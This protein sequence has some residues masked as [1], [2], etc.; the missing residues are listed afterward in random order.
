MPRAPR[1][2]PDENRAPTLQQVQADRERL[3]ADAQRTL[4]AWD[5]IVGQQEG[6]NHRFRYRFDP[7]QRRVVDN[8]DALP[9]AQAA[10]GGIGAGYYFAQAAQ[11]LLDGTQVP[12]RGVP[13]NASSASI[14]QPNG[15]W[16]AGCC[17]QYTPS[18]IRGM[19]ITNSERH[20]DRR[21]HPH[22]NIHGEHM[23]RKAI[24]S[25][26]ACMTVE[27][28]NLAPDRLPAATSMIFR[29]VRNTH[30]LSN[31]DF[32]SMMAQFHEYIGSNCAG[33][34]P[35]NIFRAMQMFFMVPQALAEIAQVGRRIL[36][37]T[38]LSGTVFMTD[39]I[40]TQM[41]WRNRLDAAFFLFAIKPS[42][43][44]RFLHKIRHRYGRATGFITYNGMNQLL[45]FTCRDCGQRQPIFLSIG[46]GATC[47]FCQH[48]VVHNAINPSHSADPI[49]H[50]LG[51]VF[52]RPTNQHYLGIELE[53]ESSS[54]TFTADIARKLR[55]AAPDK[56]ICKH[57]GSLQNGAEICTIPMTL[58]EHKSMW[59]KLCVIPDWEQGAICEE[60]S[61]PG[62]HVHISRKPA[63]LMQMARYGRF[64][65]GPGAPLTEYIA[66]RGENNYAHY[67]PYMS[68]PQL[69]HELHHG[70]E[71]DKYNV[72]NVRHPH[73]I[74]VRA[75]KS[76]KHF[77][78]LMARSEYT[79]AV[80]EFVA[81]M[82]AEELT[83]DRFL[84]WLSATPRRGQ[85]KHLAAYLKAFKI[86]PRLGETLTAA[87]VTLNMRDEP[88]LISPLLRLPHEFSN[89]A[90]GR[91]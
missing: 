51:G 42:I 12:R 63:G 32:N 3:E 25:R 15:D 85:Y 87:P 91:D 6:Q 70:E 33:D 77:D 19:L 75:Y 50:C 24:K 36:P 14:R 83:I 45:C 46:G 27:I 10:E 78:T 65:Q 43:R 23:P 90:N 56:L 29:C 60:S 61:R 30:P 2:P 21:H 66:G 13:W 39:A 37:L 20:Y 59:E 1:H 40:M 8:N 81:R 17:P 7:A 80:M 58:D 47:A 71:T 79:R 28:A 35:Q 73:T 48:R 18:T 62:L 57:D 54:R 52:N 38:Y 67:R 82:K 44:D 68:I 86:P 11:R 9:L 34:H 88:R 74:E 49:K 53:Y 31:Q 72:V 55:E 69:L 22:F 4:D 76:T 64:L 16:S 26:A 5:R 41:S 84:H 89:I